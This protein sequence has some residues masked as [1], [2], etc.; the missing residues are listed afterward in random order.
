MTWYLV[1]SVV[2]QAV[3]LLLWKESINNLPLLHVFTV[4]EFCLLFAWYA[5]QSKSFLPRIWLFGMPVL[6]LLFALLDAFVLESLHSFNIYTRSLEAFIF[7]GCSVH[8]FIRSITLE[9]KVVTGEQQALNY[10]NAG[11]FIYFS[12]SLILFAFSNY[13]NHLGR[14]LLMNIWT[15]HSLLLIVL[16]LF[17]LTGFWKTNR[18]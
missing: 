14:S 15:L 10:M 17:I 18:K 6:F 1:L 11:F 9:S 7:I 5:V 8:W 16:Y 2:T 12:G 4:L 13:I 3:S